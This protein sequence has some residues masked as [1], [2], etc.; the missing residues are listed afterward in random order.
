MVFSQIKKLFCPGCI[1][2]GLGAF[3]MPI[4]T[5]FAVYKL[6]ARF[7]MMREWQKIIAERKL[8]FTIEPEELAG[9]INEAC[10]LL[11]KHD[12]RV[13][14]LEAHC[15]RISACIGFDFNQVHVE[16]MTS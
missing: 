10:R 13:P 15:G 11:Q 4:A 9:A 8:T 2:F 1:A 16:N 3:L 6:Y 7:R 12:E 14:E 5:T